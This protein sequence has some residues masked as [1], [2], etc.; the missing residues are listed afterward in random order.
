MR[1][2]GHIAPAGIHH[3]GCKT[4]NITYR[5]LVKQQSSP[6]GVSVLVPLATGLPPCRRAGI[7]T[8]A[9]VAL[10]GAGLSRTQRISIRLIYQ[11]LSWQ[12][13]LPSVVCLL[14]P[15]TRSQTKPSGLHHLWDFPFLDPIKLLGCCFARKPGIIAITSQTNPSPTPKPHPSLPPLLSVLLLYHNVLFGTT[16]LR[17]LSLEL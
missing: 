12:S 17:V 14:C 6:R 5:G 8:Q 10:D 3:S 4:S 15:F 11:N 9:R 2:P 16:P 7:C 1:A 13:L